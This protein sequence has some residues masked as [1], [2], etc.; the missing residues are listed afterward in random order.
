MTPEQIR[1]YVEDYPNLLGKKEKLQK[2]LISLS[3]RDPDQEIVLMMRLQPI[4]RIIEFIDYAV[5]DGDILTDRESLAIE[6]R[7][8]G[9]TYQEIGEVIFLTGERTR[10]I[11]ESAYKKMTEAFNKSEIA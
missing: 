7:S 4:E 5:Y 6:F 11:I 2:Q 9:K 3:G 10:Q 8:Q 1:K